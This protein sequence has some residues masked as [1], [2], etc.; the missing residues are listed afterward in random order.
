[1]A[2]D[3]CRSPGPCTGPGGLGGERKSRFVSLPGRCRCPVRAPSC[4]PSPSATTGPKSTAR[5]P[6]RTAGPASGHTTRYTCK[7]ATGTHSSSG[8]RN[9]TD[10]LVHLVGHVIEVIGEQMPV[11]IQ[12]HRRGLVAELALHRLDVGTACDH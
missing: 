8:Y 10:W 5:T 2:A 4:A 12:R 3:R 7:A 9:L 11:Q 1:M 6:P